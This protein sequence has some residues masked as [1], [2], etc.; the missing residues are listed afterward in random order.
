MAPDINGHLCFIDKK[1][2]ESDWLS[3]WPKWDWI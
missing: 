1:T 2:D 3:Y